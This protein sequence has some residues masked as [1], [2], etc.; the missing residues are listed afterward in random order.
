MELI[1][2]IL[3]RHSL[4]RYQP[5]QITEDELNLILKAGCAAPIGMGKYEAM[6]ITVIQ[7]PEVL[8]KLSQR[9]AIL[10]GTPEFDPLYGAPTVIVISAKPYVKFPHAEYANAACMTENM[11]LAATDL[12]IGS[13]YLWSSIMAIQLDSELYQ[14][15]DLPDGFSPVSSLA[16]GYGVSP[17]SK[18]K[19]LK[20]SVTTKYL[21]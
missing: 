5:E 12:N 17:Q 2:A 16:L 10:R 13:V 15:L 6:H 20:L 8:K 7:N 18:Q 1:Q 9:A 19:E 21:R 11:L 4:R 3:S 14:Y